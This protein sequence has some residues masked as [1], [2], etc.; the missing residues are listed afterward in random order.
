V[1]EARVINLCDR[2]IAT[3]HSF[4]RRKP[5]QASLHANPLKC[6][7]SRELGKRREDQKHGRRESL[8]GRLEI[9]NRKG[10]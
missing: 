1:F 8:E 3:T 10:R 6:R 7:V 9:N 5:D 4:P 2:D